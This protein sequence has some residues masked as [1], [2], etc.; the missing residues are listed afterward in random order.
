MQQSRAVELA[1]DKQVA[2]ALSWLIRRLSLSVEPQEG[3]PLIAR[4]L[5]DRDRNRR[6]EGEKF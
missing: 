4:D 5:H 6:K 2:G 1:T 3:R